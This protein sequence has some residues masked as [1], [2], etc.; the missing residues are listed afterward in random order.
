[1]GYSLLT[2]ILYR[3]IRH[4]GVPPSSKKCKKVEKKCVLLVKN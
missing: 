1:M 4:S 2:G 3:K